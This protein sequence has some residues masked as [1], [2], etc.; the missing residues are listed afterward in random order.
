MWIRMLGDTCILGDTYNV[1]EVG[2]VPF[3]VFVSYKDL[4]LLD[5]FTRFQHEESTV[6]LIY[7]FDVIVRYVLKNLFSAKY[8]H[9]KLKK[10]RY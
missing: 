5:W 4:P 3:G 8:L 7:V 6:A 9:K 10:K 2:L 1:D